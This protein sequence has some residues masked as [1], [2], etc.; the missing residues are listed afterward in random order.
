MTVSRHGLAG[1]PSGPYLL[2]S[3]SAKGPRR[4]TSVN[5][6]LH[7][8]QSIPRVL[9]GDPCAAQ[10]RKVMTNRYERWERTKLWFSICAAVMWTIQLVGC[11]P[12][13]TASAR[14]EQGLDQGC[15]AGPFSAG[16]WPAGCWHPYADRSVF[17]RKLPASPTIAANSA[18][19]VN[20]LLSVGDLP[21]Y[22]QPGNWEAPWTADSGWPTYY[23]SA[24]RR[25]T[26]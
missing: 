5:Y 3:F 4:Q 16:W 1:S 7:L 2:E 18:A 14:S 20:R 19:V 10:R 24:S 9:A 12:G 23:S 22:T 25:G 11:A 6:E 21:S 13:D 17:N 26:P 8:E 15:Y